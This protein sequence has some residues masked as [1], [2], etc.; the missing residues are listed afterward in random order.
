MDFNGDDAPCFHFGADG[1]LAP[2][3]IDSDEATD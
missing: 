3:G 2:E 1:L